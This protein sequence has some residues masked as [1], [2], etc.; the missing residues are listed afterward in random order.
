MQPVSSRGL[1]SASACYAAPPGGGFETE[2]VKTVKALLIADS[3]VGRKVLQHCG[4]EAL[5]IIRAMG[6]HVAVMMVTT[7]KEGAQILQAFDAGADNYFIKP[8]EPSALADRVRRLMGVST[9]EGIPCG[10]RM[11]RKHRPVRRTGRNRTI[12]PPGH[13]RYLRHSPLPGLRRNRLQST[14]RRQ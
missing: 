5:K 6:K 11:R 4:F 1:R 14:R 7:A 3:G 8:F 9:E 12:H 2:D 10:R 13:L